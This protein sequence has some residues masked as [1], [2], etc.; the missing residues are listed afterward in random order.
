MPPQGFQ[1]SS[2][3]MPSQRVSN[4]PSAPPF[5]VYSL[6]PALENQDSRS[7]C[8]GR[9]HWACQESG[10]DTTCPP[11]SW[12]EIHPV[13]CKQATHILGRVGGKKHIKCN[14]QQGPQARTT[15]GGVSDISY[16]ASGFRAVDLNTRSRSLRPLR[17]QRSQRFLAMSLSREFLLRKPIPCHKNS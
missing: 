14:L 11:D 2:Y 16:P 13:A 15:P 1:Q 9:I 5:S 6:Q 8:G 7:C 4:S 10:L 12:A 17:L 3:R